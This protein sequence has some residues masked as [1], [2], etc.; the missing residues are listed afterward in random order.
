[1][2]VANAAG[3]HC[4]KCGFINA[5]STPCFDHRRPAVGHRLNKERSATAIQRGRAVVPL[6]LME[7]EKADDVGDEASEASSTW[8]VAEMDGQRRPLH[9][10]TLDSRSDRRRQ[11]DGQPGSFDLAACCCRRRSRWLGVKSTAGWCRER[12]C[13]ESLLL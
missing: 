4:S 5:S 9:V 11:H 2:T 7:V 8:V 6:P 3:R 13:L 1:V 10:V 12:K